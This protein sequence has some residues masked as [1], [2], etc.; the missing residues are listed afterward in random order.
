M[1]IDT[2]KTVHYTS[3]YKSIIGPYYTWHA[4]NQIVQI[5]RCN[6]TCQ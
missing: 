4:Y 1:Y 5:K 3:F 6:T 2:N